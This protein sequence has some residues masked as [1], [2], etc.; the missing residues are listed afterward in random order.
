MLTNR[1]GPTARPITTAAETA[2]TLEVFKE[3]GSDYE[4]AVVESF[5]NRLEDEIDDRVA[6]A[7]DEQLGER[8]EQPGPLHAALARDRRAGVTVVLATLLFG[9]VAT[10]L[11]RGL[12]A[13]A[14]LWVGMAVVNIAYFSHRN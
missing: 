7:F 10:V 13:L 12:A 14:L 4:D 9:T 1:S 6:E 11:I 5:V 3:L 2:T 8:L